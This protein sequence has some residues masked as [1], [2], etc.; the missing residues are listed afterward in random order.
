VNLPLLKLPTE[1]TMSLA[2]A[3]QQED[4]RC[5][6]IQAMQTQAPPCHQATDDASD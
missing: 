5:F 4:T 3:S 6:L 1:L 2:I